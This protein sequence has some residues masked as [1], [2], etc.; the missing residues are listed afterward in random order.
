MHSTSVYLSRVYGLMKCISN[1]AKAF[2]PLN[3][4]SSPNHFIFFY[5]D[6]GSLKFDSKLIKLQLKLQ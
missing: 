6:K 1:Q 5:T 4:T 2:N 3:G